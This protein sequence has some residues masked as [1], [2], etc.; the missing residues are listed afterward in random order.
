MLLRSA[1]CAGIVALAATVTLAQTAQ[2]PKSD[3]YLLLGNVN[4]GAGEPWVFV[5]P[6]DHNNII[7]VAM[8]TLN[9]LRDGE[10]P[11]LPRGTPAAT[12]QRIRELS[13]PDG[14]RT[15]IA[16]THDGG[17]T[18]TFSQDDLRKI[19]NKNR[20]SDSFAGAGPDGAL[21]MGCLAY[22]NRGAADYADGYAPN[23]EAHFYHGGS[24]IERSTDGGRTW[25]HPV[26][27]HPALSPSLYA[28]TVHPVFE[29]AS[30]WDRPVFVADPQTGTIY[31]SGSGLAWTVDPKTVKRPPANPNI[32]SKGYE[33][34]PGHDV[35]RGRTFLRAS[36]DH[37][38]TWGVIYPI[39]SD[40]YPG[41]RF[42]G[43][44]GFSAAFGHLVV[45]YNA[46]QVP[47]ALHRTCPCTVLGISENDGKTFA[48]KVLPPLAAE[49]APKPGSNPMRAMLG[50]MVSA[51]PMKEG[52]Y[53]VARIAGKRVVMTIT[54][55][56]GSSWGPPVVAAE[57]PDNAYIWQHAMKYSPKGDL[58]LIWKAVYSD[59]SFDLWSAVSR[60]GGKSFHTVRVSHAVSPTYIV[61]RG[62]FMFGDDLSS[63][64]ID[65][66]Y[67]YAVWGDNR[68]GF[69]ATWFGRIPLSAY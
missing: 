9:R 63:L 7:V 24:A 23:G 8:A 14:S 43:L 29:Q 32:P 49:Y 45:A 60:D 13:T 20:C 46:S 57:V 19:Y 30:P 69:E 33:G 41:G 18:W 38:R 34:Y 31:L 50:V 42:A 22:L 27:V 6:K 16:V 26:W 67:L 4:R 15:D 28:P 58:G 10:I 61:D 68:S 51:D 55:D 54:E 1:C 35:S 59:K 17:N 37:G 39:D 3:E 65:A 25:S 66:D 53:A 48:Y 44:G 36:H 47:A 56:G 21:Y 52:R 64:D 2:K 11:I 62:N 5:N 12:Q 40:A